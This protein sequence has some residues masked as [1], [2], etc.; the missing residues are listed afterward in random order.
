MKKQFAEE[1]VGVSRCTELISQELLYASQQLCQ[2]AV[3]ELFI[4]DQLLQRALLQGGGAFDELG[5]ERF[6]SGG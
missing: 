5:F 4:A 2:F 1:R 3:S 6:S